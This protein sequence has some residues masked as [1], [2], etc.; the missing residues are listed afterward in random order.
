[1]ASPPT[2]DAV[3]AYA[4][5]IITLFVK[6]FVTARFQG[7]AKYRVGGRAPED[8]SFGPILGKPRTS[9]NLGVNADPKDERMLK[10]RALEQRW[11]RILMNDLETLPFALFLFGAALLLECDGP[12]LT[13]S[14]VVFTLS[15]FWYTYYYAKA[16][17]P[18]RTL[19]YGVGILALLSAIGA[20]L[21]KIYSLRR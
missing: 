8:A 21:W 14:M 19:T 15:R 4:L 5:C 18:H 17:Q 10:L 11:D 2:S 9:Q 7:A 3:Q 13:A 20:M 16:K 6:F 1:M 12:L